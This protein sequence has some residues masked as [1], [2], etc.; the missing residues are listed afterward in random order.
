MRKRNIENLNFFNARCTTVQGN[1]KPIWKAEFFNEL[2]YPVII[3]DSFSDDLYS[4]HENSYISELN[5]YV[6]EDIGGAYRCESSITG[7]FVS[8][9][10]TSSKFRIII[11]V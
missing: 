2:N 10:L 9:I 6:T 7:V 4:Y 1:H 5:A 3:N 11:S 8:F